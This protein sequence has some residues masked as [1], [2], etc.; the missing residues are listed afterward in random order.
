MTATPGPMPDTIPT[1]QG[2]SEQA[3]VKEGALAAGPGAAD[4]PLPPG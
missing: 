2:C 3:E 4:F 1:D